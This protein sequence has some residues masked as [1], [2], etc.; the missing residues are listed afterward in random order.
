MT[1]ISLR[2]ESETKAT[3]SFSSVEIGETE[4]TTPNKAAIVWMNFH[5]N[6]HIKN[7]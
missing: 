3:G 2:A 6:H 7:L 5:S 4:G 1:S